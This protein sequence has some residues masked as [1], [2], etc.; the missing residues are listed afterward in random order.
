MTGLIAARFDPDFLNIKALFEELLII[1][2]DIVNLQLLQ[3]Q[4]SFHDFNLDV[5]AA[6]YARPG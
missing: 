1:C 5:L 4:E 2:F 6:L 3:R